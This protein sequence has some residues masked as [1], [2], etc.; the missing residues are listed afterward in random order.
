[1]DEGDEVLDEILE[2]IDDEDSERLNSLLSEPSNSNEYAQ[3]KRSSRTS[4][5]KRKRSTTSPRRGGYSE[6]DGEGNDRRRDTNEFDSGLYHNKEDRNRLEN[7][8]ELERERILAERAEK[9][10]ISDL[11]HFENSEFWI[12]I[13]HHKDLEAVQL[14]INLEDFSS[15]RRSSRTKD[16]KKKGD[17]EELKR[18]RAQKNRSH[19]TKAGSQSPEPGENVTTGDEDDMSY[20]EDEN[21]ER[22]KDDDSEP[23]F[24][25]KI[26]GCFVRLHIGLQ[27]GVEVPERVQPYLIDAND[28]VK[29]NK[30]LRLKH[31]DAVKCWQM[32]IISNGKFEQF[33]RWTVTMKIKK[34]DFPTKEA[35]I[36]KKGQIK[37]ADGY[38]LSEQDVGIMI[39]QKQ[40]LRGGI[41]PLNLL[42][43]K[44]T[45]VTQ[46]DLAVAQGNY[47]DVQTYTLRLA[48]I[49][50][51]LSET[52]RPPKQDT[53]A[54]VNERNRLKNLEDSRRAEEEARKS[55]KEFIPRKSIK[56]SITDSPTSKTN[57]VRAEQFEKT[58][59]SSLTP[60]EA[61]INEVQCNLVLPPDPDNKRMPEEFY[62]E[63]YS[64]F[65][66]EQS[67][68]L[69]RKI[70]KQSSQTQQ[71]SDVPQQQQPQLPSREESMSIQS[72]TTQPP[73][74]SWN[75]DD[76]KLLKDLH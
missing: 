2:L 27:N 40:T 5:Q 24:E 41:E 30:V 42:T 20:E 28:K 73:H 22:N 25:E 52:S 75:S 7:L 19:R 10:G 69:I 56:T 48:E 68:E 32:N 15:T 57:G 1:M 3:E 53:W 61:L 9:V 14:M 60:Y 11:L 46:K 74:S 6:E 70:V 49:D 76:A 23:F 71:Q 64:T 65:T 35:I 34:F 51:M 43:E 55:K 63:R 72:Y 66:I 50:R 8:V 12:D 39:K 4:N 58:K 18:R 47:K 36:E 13:Q 44:T 21:G 31:A 26:V 33:D 62:A 29:T 16:T 37:Y 67:L 45:L 54:R 59:K 38:I 17:L